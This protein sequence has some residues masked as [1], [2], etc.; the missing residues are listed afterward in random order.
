MWICAVG[1]KSIIYWMRV[2]HLFI[3]DR[4]DSLCVVDAP[5]LQRSVGQTHYSRRLELPALDQ[6]RDI[7]S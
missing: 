4:L 3:D 7:P 6:A 1:L 2:T 5:G